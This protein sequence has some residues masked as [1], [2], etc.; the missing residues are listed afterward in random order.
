MKILNI[1]LFILFFLILTI[2]SQIGGF[3]I[4]LWFFVFRLYKDKIMN[5]KLQIASS[6]TGFLLFYI[7]LQEKN[8]I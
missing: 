2:L 4:V 6:I 3:V 7:N 1:S 5:N 8:K